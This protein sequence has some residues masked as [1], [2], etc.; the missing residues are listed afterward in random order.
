MREMEEEELVLD[1]LGD[2]AGGAGRRAGGPHAVVA[3]AGEGN[4]P[5]VPTRAQNNPTEEFTGLQT[6]LI[7]AR[8]LAGAAGNADGAVV[9]KSRFF[10]KLPPAFLC[11]KGV[12]RPIR[13]I[14]SRFYFSSASRQNPSAAGCAGA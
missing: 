8:H 5:P 14:P 7:L 13:G 3:A 12:C 1:D 9:K 10:H 2:G 6:L 11:Q 4:G